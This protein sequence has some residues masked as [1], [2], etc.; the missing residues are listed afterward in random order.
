M[1]FQFMTQQVDRGVTVDNIGKSIEN[2]EKT[3]IVLNTMLKISKKRR[4]I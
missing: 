2:I 1:K 3:R 4:I